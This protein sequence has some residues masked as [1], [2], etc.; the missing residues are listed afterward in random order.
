MFKIQY[1][2]KLGVSG[3]L[4]QD[5]LTVEGGSNELLRIS[6]ATLGAVSEFLDTTAAMETHKHGRRRNIHGTWGIG[7]EEGEFGPEFMDSPQYPGTLGRMKELGFIN[8][9]AYSLR[10]HNQD[11][12]TGSLLFG[13][14]DTLKFEG[15]LIGMPLSLSPG[16]TYFD[17]F[18]IQLT[19]VNMFDEV[20][21]STDVSPI[22]WNTVPGVPAIPDSGSTWT[23]LPMD[24]AQNI[25]DYLN[26]TDAFPA[27][28]FG[29]RAVFVPCEIL[30]RN[31]NVT[32]Q[33]GGWNGPRITVPIQELIKRDHFEQA[34]AHRRHHHQCLL[35]IFGGHTKDAILGD[36]VLRSAYVVYDLD[37]KRIAMAQS[38]DTD[39][40]SIEPITNDTIPGLVAMLDLLPTLTMTEAASISTP[41][42]FISSTGAIS[43]GACAV[44]TEPTITTECQGYITAIPASATAISTSTTVISTVT[45]QDL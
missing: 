31:M 40:S 18:R 42:T 32:F 20:L 30:R 35:E 37:N 38:K 34:G 10:L 24:I 16:K 39:D 3:E 26:G 28:S 14:V 21:G 27:N 29:L 12:A 7:L 23:F 25:F 11:A 1:A 9:R 45:K 4:I 36:N 17:R 13:G 22:Q 6:N 41:T 44:K 8:A 15:P 33:F 43:V 19:R 2:D 5:V